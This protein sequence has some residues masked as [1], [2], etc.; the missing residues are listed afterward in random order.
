MHLLSA[1]LPVQCCHGHL[2]A[3]QHP[4]G[5]RHAA[6]LTAHGM[7]CLACCQAG[8]LACAPLSCRQ[9]KI[10]EKRME[11]KIE[12]ERNR[13]REFVNRSIDEVNKRVSARQSLQAG[14]TAHLTMQH[15]PVT[16]YTVSHAHNRSVR[17][18]HA[19]H[20]SAGCAVLLVIWFCIRPFPSPLCAGF[21][22]KLL[23]C[24]FLRGAYPHTPFA[25]P[26][27][28]SLRRS[29]FVLRRSA[30]RLSWRRR[31]ASWTRRQPSRWG[32]ADTSLYC[33]TYTGGVGVEGASSCTSSLQTRL[34]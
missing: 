21:P 9:R 33:G 22:S 8:V 20:I 10:A 31:G 29:V 3:C 1:A 7:L 28:M 17:T 18:G 12:R 4:V 19:A 34:S 11:R 16:H 25:P 24:C 14:V 32:C 23:T 13:R 5:R 2:V 27:L 15:V 30:A 6:C 26:R